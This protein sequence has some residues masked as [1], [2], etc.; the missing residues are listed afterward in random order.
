MTKIV[1][2][3]DLAI[4]GGNSIAIQSMLN[5]P[6]SDT[7]RALAQIFE[8]EQAGCEIVRAAVPDEDCARAVREVVDRTHIPLVADIHFDYRLA[9]SA[10]ENG[11][12][13]L[14]I[15]PGNIGG[16]DKVKQ[17]VD[18]LKAHRIPV[19]IGVNGGSLEKELLAKY[20]HPCAE[21]IVESAERSIAMFQEFGYDDLVISL[22]ASDVPM[23]VAANRLFAS[24]HEYPLHLGVTE[25]GAENAGMIRSSVGIGSLLLDGIGDTLRVSLT[26]NP[27]P[28]VAAAKEILAA[29]NLRREGVRV[30]SCPTCGRCK[31]DL[32]SYVK[33]FKER[34]KEIKEPVTVAVMGCA[35]NGPGEAREADMGVACGDGKGVLFRGG[36]VVGSVPAEGIVNALHR[37]IL[38]LIESRKNTL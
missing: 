10:V 32:L 7:E 29:C 22:K 36:E 18:C 5:V 33:A 13:K 17:V 28:E 23:T 6:L 16:R 4:G 8:L 21:A 20:G 14:R 2:I 30:I 26:G 11:V 12:S 19:R 15:N 27:V 9:I 37:E 38:A 35:V 24:R 31:T 34:T 25:A 1:K 3:G